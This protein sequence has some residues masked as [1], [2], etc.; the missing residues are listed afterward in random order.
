[1][2]IGIALSFA[3][4]IHSA[5]PG[6][7]RKLWEF[8]AGRFGAESSGEALG[9][10]SLSFSPDGRRI[11]AVVG[12]A[13]DQQY[14]LLMDAADPRSKT[15]RIDVNPTIWES[16]IGG[17][18]NLPWSPSG[19]YLLLG[20]HLLQ[21][22][23]AATCELPTSDFLFL[24]DRQLVGRSA[25]QRKL[26][27]YS[28]DCKSIREWPESNDVLFDSSPERG[29]ICVRHDTYGAGTQEHTV[30]IIEVP[31]SRVVRQVPW[32]I[33][34]RFADSGTAI[35]G[36]DGTEWHRTAACRN[37]DTG[38]ELAA[39]KGWTNLDLRAASRSQRVVL[40][41]SGR[42]L[43]FID[44]VWTNGPLKRRVVWD[45][46]TGKELLSWRPMSQKIL[47][48][49]RPYDRSPQSQPYRFAI[50]PN[51]DFVVEGGAGTISLYKIQP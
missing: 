7:L 47:L 24:S 14:L 5:C 41:D 29:L 30:S 22:D 18:I 9:V 34:V 20:R 32:A 2:R 26:G 50:S 36:V 17:S 46:R 11:A 42:R 16:D 45:I 40:S 15:V 21:V 28:V 12:K 33:R 4:A 43:D 35:C 8:N 6:D 38:A 19:D 48:G 13:W 10:F 44:L 23:R 51:G 49:N 25:A 1:M 3:F 39:T 37:V 27:L 31:A